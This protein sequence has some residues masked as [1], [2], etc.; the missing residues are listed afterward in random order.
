[1]NMI[2]E[3]RPIIINNVIT[4]YLI[5]NTGY[6]KNKKT[7]RILTNSLSTDGYYC[8]GISI[9]KKNYRKRVHRLVAEAFIENK[10]NYPY[11]NHKN[12]I[13][14]DNRMDNLEWCTPQQNTRHAWD[15]GLAVSVKK[16]K[17]K[18]YDLNGDFIEEYNSLSQA[19]KSLN[20][21]ESK[22]SLC[23]NGLRK[24]HGGFQWRFSDDE[25]PGMC[26]SK[27]IYAKKVAQYDLDDNLLNIYDS[28]G[29][30]AKAVN[31]T[32]S[33]ISRCCNNK[34]KTHKGFKWRFIVDEIVQ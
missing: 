20:L 31:G 16:I 18:Q 6:V 21:L 22:I 27:I 8:V 19:A 4:N 11:V 5:S 12:G 15:T 7:N 26:D 9:N 34:A 25:A 29:K 10:Y 17:I 14:T 13:K 28:T 23:C 3:W 33:A 30:A 1:M 2:E 32:Q 24:S